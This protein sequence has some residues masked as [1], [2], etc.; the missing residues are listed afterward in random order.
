MSGSF[1]GVSE[2]NCFSV[3][4]RP[5]MKNKLLI[6]QYSLAGGG[7]EKVLC[8]ILNRIDYDRFDVTLLLFQKYGV[9]LSAVPEKVRIKVFDPAEMTFGWKLLFNRWT[10]KLVPSGLWTRLKLHKALGLCGK[11]DCIVSFMEGWSVAVHSK[12]RSRARRNVT[13]V[14][15]DM[16]AN[17]YSS[18]FFKNEAAETEAYD[19]MDEIVFV[20]EQAREAFF[21]LF[22]REY[23]ARVIYNLIEKDDIIRK[24]SESCPVEKRR[25]YVL[26]NV[27]RLAPQKRQDRL[28]RVVA[29]LWHDYG[30]DV[31]AWIVGEGELEA[32]LRRLAKD[33]KVDDRV[34]F[35]GFQTN[36]Y[37]LIK[38]ADIF[39]LT[40]DAEGLPVVVSEALC[41]GKPIVATRITGPTELLAEDAGLLTSMDEN[42][43]AL[44]IKAL[45]DD[46]TLR[47]HYETMARRRSEM[48]CPDKSIEQ[49]YAVISGE[50][51]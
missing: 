33:L 41:L 37:P 2:K 24:S 32:D 19:R 4:E 14:H 3:T 46:C 11:Y 27:G 49:I 35:C 7:A 43:I 6:I 48:F 36:P 29:R 17:H 5:C 26:C 28:I 40:S 18:G 22:A 44:K 16:L 34:V 1:T 15:I 10:A 25:K 8:D 31:E 47:G 45:L 38:N 51:S 13:W 21:K 12:L 30:L 23:P 9:Y 42:E 50:N 39:V 20:S